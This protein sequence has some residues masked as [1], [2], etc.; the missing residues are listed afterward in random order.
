VGEPRSL[1]TGH[2][3]LSFATSASSSS[4]S[5]S[6]SLVPVRTLMVH[7]VLSSQ[8]NEMTLLCESENWPSGPPKLHF[9]IFWLISEAASD[10]IAVTMIGYGNFPLLLFKDI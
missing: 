8:R 4:S 2:S 7:S 10:A 5:S 9:L 6:S 1:L 3:A